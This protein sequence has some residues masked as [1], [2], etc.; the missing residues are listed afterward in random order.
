MG[1]SQDPEA[2]TKVACLAT[3]TLAKFIS[4]KMKTTKLSERA[5]Q[6]R[7]KVQRNFVQISY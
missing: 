4:L 3:A 5:D 7:Q 6:K 2:V 1:R